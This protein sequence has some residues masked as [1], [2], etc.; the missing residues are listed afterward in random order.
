MPYRVLILDDDRHVSE[1][2]AMQLDDEGFMTSQAHSAEDAL[3]LL[4]DEPCD[5]VIV[6][7]RLPGMNGIDFINAASRGWG[8]LRFI[9][10]TGSPEFHIP[11]SMNSME[12]VSEALFLKPLSDYATLISEIRNM[13]D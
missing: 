11:N 6:D 7:L 1:S 5:I 13:L 2:L 4:E 3:R 10:Y 9:I 8:K 12:S